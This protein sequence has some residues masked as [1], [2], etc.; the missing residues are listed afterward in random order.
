MLLLFLRQT[1]ILTGVVLGKKE[2]E[3]EKK[4]Q[5]GDVPQSWQLRRQVS[6]GLSLTSL[7]LFHTPQEAK[8]TSEP[9]ASC[10]E[11]FSQGPREN[12]AQLSGGLD[13]QE[14][15]QPDQSQWRESAPRSLAGRGHKKT[16]GQEPRGHK[17]E[18]IFWWPGLGKQMLSW[19]SLNVH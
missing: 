4:R 5:F 16:Q 17:L 8:K 1:L 10:P 9:A 12:I 2:K 19:G 14:R 11:A 15:E 13:T 6:N 7:S 3:K 18:S